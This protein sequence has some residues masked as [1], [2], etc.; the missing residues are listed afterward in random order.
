MPQRVVAQDDLN[1]L[2]D[3]AKKDLTEDEAQKTPEVP[4]KDNTPDQKRAPEETEPKEV[5]EKSDQLESPEKTDE[6]KLPEKDDSNGEVQK[7]VDQLNKKITD[8]EKGLRKVKDNQ[9]PVDNIDVDYNNTI[10]QSSSKKYSKKMVISL[11]DR[12]D[13]VA[14]VVH[15]INPKMASRIDKV[16][17]T[18]YD[19]FKQIGG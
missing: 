9:I 17:D 16:A 11:F 12:L 2:F 5:P 3:E 10:N 8:L 1:E 19:Y 15:E 18:L 7:T 13:E 4:E 6:E 14:E